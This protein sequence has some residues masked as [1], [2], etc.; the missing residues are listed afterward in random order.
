MARQAH[1]QHLRDGGLVLVDH[2]PGLVEIPLRQQRL[3]LVPHLAIL[4]AGAVQ[5]YPA[6]DRYGR[7]DRKHEQ[8]G[9]HEHPALLKKRHN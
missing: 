9:I 5:L 1:G 6:L 8:N 7:T 2:F 4:V 3:N